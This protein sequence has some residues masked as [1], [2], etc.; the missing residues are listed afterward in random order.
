MSRVARD[1]GPAG[2]VARVIATA[3][4]LRHVEEKHWPRLVEDLVMVHRG[5]TWLELADVYGADRIGALNIAYLRAFGPKLTDQLDAEREE[6][7]ERIGG[8]VSSIFEW[9]SL[10]LKMFEKVEVEIVPAPASVMVGTMRADRR[11]VLYSGPDELYVCEPPSKILSP[12]MTAAVVAELVKRP[13]VLR[14]GLLG[15]TRSVIWVP[16][17]S[18]PRFATR[19]KTPDGPLEIIGPAWR[20]RGFANGV[21]GDTR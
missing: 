15:R 9:V 19:L 8:D 11:Y 17:A 4:R 10:L 5:A 7:R 18:C 1:A 16:D 13:V 3:C 2:A 21:A 14:G 12:P 6:R 20:Q